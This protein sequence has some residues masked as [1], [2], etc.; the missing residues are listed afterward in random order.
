[1]H[2]SFC[3]DRLLTVFFCWILMPPL[4]LHFFSIPIGYFKMSSARFWM[5]SQLITLHQAVI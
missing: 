2:F 3:E 1:M 4:I 5:Y